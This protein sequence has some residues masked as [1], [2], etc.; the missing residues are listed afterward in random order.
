MSLVV[1]PLASVASGFP[2]A[3]GANRTPIARRCRSRALSVREHYRE[4]ERGE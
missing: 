1:T 3:V 4:V 2:Y